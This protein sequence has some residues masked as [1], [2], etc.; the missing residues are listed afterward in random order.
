MRRWLLGAVIIM[1]TAVSGCGTLVIRST[2]SYG[3][4][5]NYAPHYHNHTPEL[6]RWHRHCYYNERG[7]RHCHRHYH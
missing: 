3:Y 2:P 7:R 5:P 4:Y 1:A 6:Q